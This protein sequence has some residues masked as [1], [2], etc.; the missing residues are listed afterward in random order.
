MPSAAVC[1]APRCAR[2]ASDTPPR[3]CALDELPRSR[4]RWRTHHGRRHPWRKRHCRRRRR[5]P[6]WKL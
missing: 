2:P 4:A 3:S 6:R 5:R 1:A